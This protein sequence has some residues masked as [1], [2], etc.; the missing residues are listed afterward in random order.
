MTYISETLIEYYF[1]LFDSTYSRSGQYSWLDIDNYVINS[2][3][4]QTAELGVF[5]KYKLAAFHFQYLRSD[6]KFFP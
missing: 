6:R 5:C 3:A 2:T 1:F 4:Q